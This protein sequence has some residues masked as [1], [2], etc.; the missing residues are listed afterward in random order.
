MTALYSNYY[1]QHCNLFITNN[2]FT[3]II[4]IIKSLLSSSIPSKL[5]SSSDHYHKTKLTFF[6]LGYHALLLYVHPPA[7]LHVHFPATYPKPVFKL[8]PF[9]SQYWH[10]VLHLKLM[11]PHWPFLHLSERVHFCPSSQD[12]PFLFVHAEVVEL[13]LHHW[14]NRFFNWYF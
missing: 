3:I 11:P 13:G 4:M 7:I 10:S 5:K 12:I 6:Y 8:Q 9:P 2:I 14:R 1:H